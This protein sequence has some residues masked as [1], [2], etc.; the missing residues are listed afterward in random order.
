MADDRYKLSNAY[1][2]SSPDET[3]EFYQGWASGYEAEITE[4]GYI[5]PQ[6]CAGALVHLAAA[7]WA[8]IMDLGCGTGVSGLAL[9]AAGFECIDGYDFSQAMLD[10]AALKGIYRDLAIAD[11]SKPLEIT[12]GMYQNAAAVGCITPD[13]MPATVLDEILSK[14]P[15]GGYL[16]FSVNDHSVAD[17][18]IVGRIMTLTDCGAADLVFK[19]YGDH[20]PGIG[21]KSTVYGLKKR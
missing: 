21:L 4:N 16:V 13:Y 9:K 6:R 17:G 3:H 15:T 14:L 2:V 11:M 18:S 19:E 8:P 12:E 5:T 10:Q 1:K 20:L 7:P